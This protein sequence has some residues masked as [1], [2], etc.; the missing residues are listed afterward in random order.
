LATWTKNEGLPFLIF[1]AAVVAWRGGA[2]AL[3][4]LMTGAAPVLILTL[5]FKLILVEGREAMFPQTVPKALR[6]I[7]DLSR[8]IEIVSSFARNFWEMGFP[9]AHPV[10][11]VAVLV[12]S[13][14]LA[15]EARERTWLF[16]AP[17]G[18]LAADFGIYLIT[19]TGLTWHLST[20]NNRVIAQV[21]P[22]ILL[23]CF[24]VLRPPV[25][26]SAPAKKKK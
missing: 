3:K 18:L 15:P 21:W 12:W 25:V 4:W 14:G 22:A 16:I 23:A 9:W 5:A 6:M 19:N 13:L 1:A 11:L 24:A 7:G 26:A 17:L 8:W 20:S 2:R 10:L